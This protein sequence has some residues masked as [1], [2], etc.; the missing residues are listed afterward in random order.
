MDGRFL[1][2]FFYEKDLSDSII[3]QVIGVFLNPDEHIGFS[4]VFFANRICLVIA[5]K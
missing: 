2:G 1:I 3:M 5:D 4:L